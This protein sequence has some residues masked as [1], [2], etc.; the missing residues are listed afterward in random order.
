MH[1]AEVRT[2]ADVE[3]GNPDVWKA[4][5]AARQEWQDTKPTFAQLVAAKA[6]RR[7]R[8]EQFE[9]KQRRWRNLV[10]LHEVFCWLS[11]CDDAQNATASKRIDIIC[12]ALSET[13]SIFRIGGD[14]LPWAIIAQ[15]DYSPPIS[16]F[17][18][19]DIAAVRNSSLY[20]DSRALRRLIERLW[21]PREV[22]LKFFQ[23]KLWMWP[24]CLDTPTPPANPAKKKGRPEGTGKYVI[25]AEYLEQC[26]PEKEIAR[27]ISRKILKRDVID[28]VP[29]LNG[30]LDDDTLKKAID[31]HNEIVAQKQR[32]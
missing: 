1:F 12:R 20:P 28:A 16:M 31:F 17:F 23:E 5:E 30:S 29:V 10:S 15:P 19:S 25:V 4:D 26:F 24:P 22:L 8:I 21:V 9:Q 18:A 14:L 13:Q 3:A 11:D 7:A 32:S 27:H 2:M 6:A